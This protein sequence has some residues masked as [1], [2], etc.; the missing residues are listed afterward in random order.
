MLPV[1]QRIAER[2]M[3]VTLTAAE[4]ARYSRHI[5]LPQLGVDGQKCLK[6]ARVLV[7]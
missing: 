1:S 7:V 6:A 2:A 5:L 4:I 3:D